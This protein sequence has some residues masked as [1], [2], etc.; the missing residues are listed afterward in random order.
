MQKLKKILVTEVLILW[1]LSAAC[2]NSDSNIPA[3][4]F[5]VST[6]YLALVYHATYEWKGGDNT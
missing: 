1:L 5:L 2:L 6:I 3:I 4:V